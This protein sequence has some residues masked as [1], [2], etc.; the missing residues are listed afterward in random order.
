M[1]IELRH[2]ITVRIPPDV[3]A[4]LRSI[5]SA[6]ERTVSDVVRHAVEGVS[7]RPRQQ[8]RGRRELIRQLNRIGNNLNQQTRLLHLL[9]HR[10]DLPDLE[11]IL[12]VLGQVEA[13]VLSVSRR[14]AQANQE[15]AARRPGRKDRSPGEL[16]E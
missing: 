1:S 3:H 8:M 10:G 4:R 16:G 15:P 9:R 12:M 6:S 13:T 5:A 11:A 2:R 7:V 14:V